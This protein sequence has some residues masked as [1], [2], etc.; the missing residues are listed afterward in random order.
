M[1]INAV[2]IKV[3]ISPFDSEN[4]RSASPGV[5]VEADDEPVPWIGTRLKKAGDF[6]LGVDLDG[7][8]GQF[9]GLDRFQGV[10]GAIF[11]FL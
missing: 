1:N 2:T 11:L 8:L 5:H 6:V 10:V 3:N 9:W 4:F 7:V